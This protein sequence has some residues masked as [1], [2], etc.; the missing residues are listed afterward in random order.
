MTF[1]EALTLALVSEPVNGPTRRLG[2]RLD[3][4][5]NKNLTLFE[6][7][8]K[9]EL[10]SHR[11]WITGNPPGGL[12]I[13]LLEG[14][15]DGLTLV[16]GV[17]VAG[18]GL[19]FSGAAQPLVQLDALSI[20]AIEVNVFAEA[21]T[22]GVGGGARLK[23]EGLAVAPAAKG[24]TQLGR[25]QPAQGLRLV[26]PGGPPLVQPVVRAAEARPRHGRLRQPARR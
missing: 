15:E 10:V 16:P 14:T 7:D 11:D 24:G 1:G 5:A 19:R 22:D 4:A 6:G 18:L 9:V 25:Q 13:F 23:L 26:R 3:L 8:P 17:E 21:T 20:D 12:S 2:V